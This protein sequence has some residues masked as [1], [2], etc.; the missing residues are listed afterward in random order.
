MAQVQSLLHGFLQDGACPCRSVLTG[1]AIVD[2][3]SQTWVETCDRICTP[4]VTL[5]P[6]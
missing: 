6:F 3:I 2:R 1:Q 4:V 5:W